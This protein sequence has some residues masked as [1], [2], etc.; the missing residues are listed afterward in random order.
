MFA[1]INSPSSQQAVQSA[2]QGGYHPAD[3][4]GQHNIYSSDMHL[5]LQ[6]SDPQLQMQAFGHQDSPHFLCQV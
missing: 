6:S 5:Q 2:I 4:Q 1:D 3:V